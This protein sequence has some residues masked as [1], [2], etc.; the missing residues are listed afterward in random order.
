[1]KT[2][3]FLFLV[4]GALIIKLATNLHDAGDLTADSVA[5]GVTGI[6]EFKE[7]EPK[8]EIIS[9]DTKDYAKT[10]DRRDRVIVVTFWDEFSSDAKTAT[11]ELERAIKVLPSKVLMCKVA[12]GKN[13]K[14]ANYL[15]IK[16]TPVVKI[17]HK[18]VMAN[19]FKGGFIAADVVAAANTCILKEAERGSIELNNGGVTPTGMRKVKAGNYTEL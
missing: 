11:R 16:D 9:I 6:F 14:L 13:A 19:E 3:F 18:G 4:I 8:A 2:F 15:S 7:K 10:I 5:Q 12:I 17:Y 1:M